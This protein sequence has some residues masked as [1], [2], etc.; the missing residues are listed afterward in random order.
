MPIIHNTPISVTALN[1][2]ID[3][4]LDIGGHTI[5]NVT[6]SVPTSNKMD[7]S[8]AGWAAA[9]AMMGGA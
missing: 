3:A 4:D 5:T 8:T 9:W 1:D 6:M 2:N 7:A